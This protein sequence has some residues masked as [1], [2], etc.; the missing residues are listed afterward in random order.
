M[1]M[2]D[3]KLEAALAAARA[4]RRDALTEPEPERDP[5][6]ILTPPP[7]PPLG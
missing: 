3:K 1:S 4:D 7:A 5:A 2:D 6:A